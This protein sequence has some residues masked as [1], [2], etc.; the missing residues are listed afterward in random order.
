MD[1]RIFCPIPRGVFEFKWTEGF[2]ATIYSLLTRLE[3][4]LVRKYYFS[5]SEPLGF[6]HW[7]DFFK[8]FWD[9]ARK[10]KFHHT[11]PKVPNTNPRLVI[12]KEHVQGYNEK[13][14]KNIFFLKDYKYMLDKI[15]HYRDDIQQEIENIIQSKHLPENYS[16]IHIR[17]GD[18]TNHGKCPCKSEVPEY[19]EALRK[20]D[21]NPECVFIATDDERIIQEVKEH[22]PDIKTLSQTEQQGF[23]HNTFFSTPYTEKRNIYLQ[24]FAEIEIATRSKYFIGTYCSVLSHLMQARH[25]LE[26]ST[27]VY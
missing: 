5:M 8:P 14:G 21:P 19:I 3:H 6:G 24:L 20:L 10:E 9:H 15:Y 26:N 1:P 11:L 16:C 27:L 25:G 23:D 13:N 4:C 12:Y 17:R 2:G 22:L 18:R 7:T